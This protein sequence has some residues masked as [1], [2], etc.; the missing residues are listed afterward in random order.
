V[1]AHLQAE[2]ANADCPIA[3]FQLTTRA[4]FM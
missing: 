4:F 2:F 1:L 3:A